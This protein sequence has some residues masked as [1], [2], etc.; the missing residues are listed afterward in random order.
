MLKREL[1]KAG[2]RPKRESIECTPDL[3]REY[4]KVPSIRIASRTTVVQYYDYEITELIEA[5]PDKVEIPLQMHIGAPCVP[6]VQAGDRVRVGQLI[7]K[8][9]DGGMGANI[10]A[11]IDG[12]VRSVDG[13]IV[14]LAN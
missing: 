5:H 9:K 13:K 2:I 3:E 6:V 1:G 12:M 14:I 8:P 4:R 11:S 10:H 7:A